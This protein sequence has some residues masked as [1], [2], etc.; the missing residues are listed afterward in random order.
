MM[1][2]L[3]HLMCLTFANVAAANA[4]VVVVEKI[5]NM[6]VMKKL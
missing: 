4:L 3:A 2:D 5:N 6:S 1:E